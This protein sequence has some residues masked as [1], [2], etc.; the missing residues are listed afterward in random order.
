MKLRNHTSIVT[1][2][3]EGVAPASFW[4]RVTQGIYQ[5]LVAGIGLY[6]VY[7]LAMQMIYFR[8]PGQIES[9]RTL[10]SAAHAGELVALDVVNNQLV[11]KGDRLLAIQSDK[12][13]EL[14]VDTRSGKLKE[15]IQLAQLDHQLIDNKVLFLR[16]R[17]NQ[18]KVWRALELGGRRSIN[19]HSLG[20]EISLAE[21]RLQGTNRQLKLQKKL[22]K[23]WQQQLAERQQECGPQWV[24]APFSGSIAA[25]H[26]Q[27]FEYA[28]RA[29]PLV[30]LIASPTVVSIELQID[31][32]DSEHFSVGDLLTV[33]LPNGQISDARVTR[34]ISNAALAPE[35]KQDNYRP[36]QTLTRVDLAPLTAG[37]GARW[38]EFDRADVTVITRR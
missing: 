27:Q 20:E 6:L 36:V 24:V 4:S 5:L 22:L 17:L 34:M 3:P 8:A 10:I 35:R 16:Q 1:Q 31:E 9:Q 13:C 23:D 11:E 12:P 38:M 15:A 14:L 2:L 28:S 21:Q 7:L 26:L 37:D 33:E 25:V 19:A 18:Q 30:T 32:Q 29:A